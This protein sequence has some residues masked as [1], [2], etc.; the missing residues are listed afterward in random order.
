MSAS[1]K[2]DGFSSNNKQVKQ[3]KHAVQ[4]KSAD[5]LSNTKSNTKEPAW[6]VTMN[7][8]NVSGFNLV[9]KDLTNNDPVNI[10]L[11]NIFIKADDFKNFGSEN[12]HIVINMDFNDKGRISIKGNLIPSIL[13]ADLDLDLNKIDIKSLQPYFTDSIR[14]LITDGNIQAKGRLDMNMQDQNRK[15]I[16]FDFKGQTSVNNF[17]CLDKQSAEDFFKCNSL[18]LAGLEASA[19]PI[20]IKIKDISLTDFY[21]RIIISRNGEVNLNSIFKNDA[22]KKQ[23]EKKLKVKKTAEIA[24]RVDK[25]NK[26]KPDKINIS[27]VKGGG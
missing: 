26:V 22:V 13:K 9:F 7:S 11:S 21:S 1:G 25:E 4:V 23:T 2:Q 6:K 8:L 17:I 18:Y 15:K 14:V 5:K 20:R 19:Y 16:K 12:G 10:N 27:G 24:Q 3:I